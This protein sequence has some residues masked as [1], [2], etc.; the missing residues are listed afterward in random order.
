M[1]RA[2]MRGGRRR[3]QSLGGRKRFWLGVLLVMCVCVG[4][5]RAMEAKSDEHE[6]LDLDAL[7]Q[8]V[9]QDLPPRPPGVRDGWVKGYGIGRK[10]YVG[11]SPSPTSIQTSNTATSNIPNV[12][13]KKN[14][15]L[16]KTSSPRSEI[17]E[18]RSS[19][20]PKEISTQ[21]DVTTGKMTRCGMDNLIDLQRQKPPTRPT[22]NDSSDLFNIFIHEKG[23]WSYWENFRP[24]GCALRPCPSHF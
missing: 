12:P 20:A 19:H 24:Q 16:T 9:I 7:V 17:H 11:G 15:A 3:K 2:M 13:I 21:K 10:E 22:I 18:F 5:S 8:E 4:S 1:R 14:D 23:F 6:N